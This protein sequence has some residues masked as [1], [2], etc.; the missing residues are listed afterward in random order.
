MIDSKRVIEIAE[1]NIAGTDMF[2][3]DCTSSPSGDIEL[4]IDSDTSE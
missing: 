2:V 4:I 1:R 3:V